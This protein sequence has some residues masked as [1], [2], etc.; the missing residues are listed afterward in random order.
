MA[1]TTFTTD[2]TNTALLRCPVCGQQWIEQFRHDMTLWEMSGACPNTACRAQVCVH[3]GV[4]RAF[5][6]D[7]KRAKTR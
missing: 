1:Q 6:T 3:N 4:V 5:V 7:G 2:D